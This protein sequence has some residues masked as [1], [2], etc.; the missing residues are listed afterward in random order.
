[1]MTARRLTLM[2][3]LCHFQELL[4]DPSL[5]EMMPSRM[6]MPIRA[7]NAR[8]P[9]PVRPRSRAALYLVKHGWATKMP[10]TTTKT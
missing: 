8:R 4:K 7:Q 6:L 1:M 2:L 3:S 5:T 10:M 9:D